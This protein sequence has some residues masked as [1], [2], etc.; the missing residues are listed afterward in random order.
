MVVRATVM[1]TGKKEILEVQLLHFRIIIHDGRTVHHE[2]SIHL[3]RLLPSLAPDSE[4]LICKGSGINPTS[5]TQ[6]V[7][8]ETTARH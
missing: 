2:N 5:E 7:I 8:L 6:P 3:C 4:L 1:S